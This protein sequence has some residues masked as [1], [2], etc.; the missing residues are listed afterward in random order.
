MKR[1]AI[2]FV[3]LA[4]IL[5]ACQSVSENIAEN[6]VEKVAEQADGVGDVDFDIESGEVSIETDEG[7]MTI[8]GGEIPDGFTI[9][10]PDGYAVTSVFTSDG[11]AAVSLAYDNGSYADIEAFY[12]DWT[13]GQSAEWSK[14][15]SSIG[16]EEGTLD[17]ANWSDNEGGSFISISN[18]CLVLDESIDP[19][20]CVG[21]NLNSSGE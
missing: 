10:A 16:T 3:A 18:L 17:S 8:G 6:I 2:A 13:S 5:T 20:N 4:L 21:V 9:P 15:T 7:S 12:D 1:I 14:S 19:E 11:S